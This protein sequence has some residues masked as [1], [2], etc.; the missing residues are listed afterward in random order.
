MFCGVMFWLNV[1]PASLLRVERGPGRRAVACP[2]VGRSLRRWRWARPVPRP[3]WALS[4]SPAG[5]SVRGRRVS[6]AQRSDTKPAGEA[7]TVLTRGASNCYI[8]ITVRSLNASRG[9]QIYIPSKPCCV[10]LPSSFL[11]AAINLDALVDINILLKNFTKL[12]GH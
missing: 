4:R 1:T 6:S 10:L 8:Y 7:A 3:C 2:G 5:G 12:C 9:R 11:P